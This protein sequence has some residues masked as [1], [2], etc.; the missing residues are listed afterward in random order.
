M[1]YAA[2]AVVE[3]NAH[4]FIYFLRGFSPSAGPAAHTTMGGSF[5]CAAKLFSEVAGGGG[6]GWRFCPRV[7]CLF[8]KRRN[9]PTCVYIYTYTHG[10]YLYRYMQ[11]CACVCTVLVCVCVIRYE[12]N[13]HICIRKY[14]WVCARTCTFIVYVCGCVGCACVCTRACDAYDCG[15]SERISITFWYIILYYYSRTRW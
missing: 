7:R 3:R 6:R 4:V 14:K 11:G 13:I 2:A 10:A 5:V 15:D 8:C 12:F 1:P 9:W